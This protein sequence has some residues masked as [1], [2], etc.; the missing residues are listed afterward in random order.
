[1]VYIKNNPLDGK[2]PSE[3]EKFE[4]NHKISSLNFN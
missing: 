3:K 4:K 1:M 2:N